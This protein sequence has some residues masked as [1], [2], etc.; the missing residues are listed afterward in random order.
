MSNFCVRNQISIDIHNIKP[1][2]K[3][4]EDDKLDALAWINSGEEIFRIEKPAT[5]PKHLVVYF[6]LIDNESI[7][8]VNHIAAQMWLPAGGHVNP[9]ELPSDSVIREC[10]EELNIE[11][12]FLVA[13]PA[14]ISITETVGK[15]IKHTDV[16]LWYA[17]KGF[18]THCFEFDQ[19]EFT[20]VKWFSFDEIP[21][22]N[23][24]PQ[25]ERFVAKLKKLS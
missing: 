22:G 16:S 1:L 11:A 17:I 12:K 5:P 4:E 25:L 9:N 15:T 20:E 19:R 21:L 6:A 3:L 18:Q 10:L 13:G 2:D 8:L 7:L 14:M 23:C 24:D